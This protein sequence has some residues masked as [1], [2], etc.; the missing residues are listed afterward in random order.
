MDGYQ[1]GD[2]VALANGLTVVVPAGL[3][4]SMVRDNPGG[5]TELFWLLDAAGESPASVRALSAEDLRDDDE[6][7]LQYKLVAR[8]SDRTVEVRWVTGKFEG[9]RRF[10]HVAIVT[11]LPGKLTGTVVPLPAYGDS[12]AR[13]RSD[14]LRQA[15]DLWGLLTV[16]GA[17]LPDETN[18]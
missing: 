12:R 8:S 1:P 4:A 7:F 9:G 5:P 18:Y 3:T 11:H 15:A 14:A 6:L 2:E 17:E 16:T 13:N 10:S